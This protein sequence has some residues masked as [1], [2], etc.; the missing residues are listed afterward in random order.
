MLDW[1]E[2]AKQYK[3]KH[4]LQAVQLQCKLLLAGRQTSSASRAC[5][6][7]RQAVLACSA[8]SACKQFPLSHTHSAQGRF[9]LNPANIAGATAQWATVG[10]SQC[11]VG[12]WHWPTVVAVVPVRTCVAHISINVANSTGL[13]SVAVE[14]CSESIVHLAFALSLSLTLSPNGTCEIL[15][16]LVSPADNWIFFVCFAAIKII[17]KRWFCTLCENDLSYP[18]KKKKT[19]KDGAIKNRYKAQLYFDTWC[20]EEYLRAVWWQFVN[21]I[22]T[23][24]NKWVCE[25]TK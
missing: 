22:K 3:A 23:L 12:G 6:M 4:A 10:G 17:I 2:H 24:I 11:F 1:K 21:A 5:S 15:L 13:S 9:N 14:R 25:T 8:S 20:A 7:D 16:I 18:Q 19:N